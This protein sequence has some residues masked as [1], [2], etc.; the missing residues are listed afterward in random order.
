MTRVHQIKNSVLSN[1]KILMSAL[2]GALWSGVLAPAAHG[3]P[4]TPPITFAQYEE[5]VDPGN[6]NLFAYAETGTAL[7]GG[8]AQLTATNVPITF[9]YETL[10][11][12]ADL[13]GPQDATLTLT[14]STGQTVTLALSNSLGQEIFNLPA[15]D[16][17]TLTRDTPA[18]EGNGSRDILLQMTAFTGQLDG[19]INSHA[20]VLTGSTATGDSISYASDFLDF[21]TVTA[22]DYSLNFTSWNTTPGGSGLGVDPVSNF[23]N[24]ATAAGTG[25]FDAGPSITVVVPEP[26][27]ALAA[28]GLGILFLRRRPRSA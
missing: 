21:T 18:A 20:A 3:I 11:M 25:S 13:T 12:P 14:T 16:T 23:Y 7:T 22:K 8:S 15:G 2:V 19:A 28:A 5:A 24:A 26:V 4:V 1:K 17:L 9:H 27:T 6:A 10:A